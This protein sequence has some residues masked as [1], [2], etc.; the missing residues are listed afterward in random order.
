M[1]ERSR[2]YA[3]LGL[4]SGAGPVEVKKA[5]K[6]LVRTWHPDRFA[7]DPVGQADAARQMARINL[8]YQLLERDL[9]P[10]H[11]APSVYEPPRRPPAEGARTSRLTR[12]QIDGMIAAIG[13]KSPIDSF[14]DWLWFA[15]SERPFDLPI[16]RAHAP[17]IAAILLLALVPIAAGL[18]WG[19]QVGDRLSWAVALPAVVWL[20]WIRRRRAPEAGR[21]R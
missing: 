6:R 3:T 16:D 12:D 13:T 4:P 18:L 11:A 9:D 20:L 1:D 10:A 7:A 8:A 17:Q 21:G 2:A 19:R 14:L 15:P 5:Y